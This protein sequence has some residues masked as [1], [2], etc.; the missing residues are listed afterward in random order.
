[1]IE[2]HSFNINVAKY[3]ERVENA[4]APVQASSSN[5]AYHSKSSNQPPSRTNDLDGLSFVV[6]MLCK[7]VAKRIRAL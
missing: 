3:I 6:V 4:F 2:W 1:M 7:V 5:H